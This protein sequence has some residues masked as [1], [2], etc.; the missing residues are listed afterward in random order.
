MTGSKPP[1]SS[2]PEKRNFVR[3][4]LWFPVT[5]CPVVSGDPARPARREVW[6]ICRDASAGGMLVSAAAPLDA[7]QPVTARFR[8]AID[9]E[10][11]IAE[12]EVVRAE[13]N[14]GELMLAFPFRVGLKFVPPLVDLPNELRERLGL[15]PDADDAT[16]AEE[17]GGQR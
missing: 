14:D 7:H 2:F 9:G 5:L 6:A 4:A 12:G 10:E 16:A 3:Y 17:S 8:L 15:G 11:H 1:S 13:A